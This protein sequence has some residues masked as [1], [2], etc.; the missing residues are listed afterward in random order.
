MGAVVALGAF[1]TGP[2][3]M[4]SALVYVASNPCFVLLNRCVR[5]GRTHLRRKRQA[6][7]GRPIEQIAAAARRLG[8]QLLHA[9]DG[10]SR[11]RIDAIRR[12]YDDVLAEGCRA[13]GFTHLLGVLAEGPE[14]DYERRRVEVMLMGAGMALVDVY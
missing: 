11:T 8:G 5:W 3:L 12:S 14:L 6:P 13:L 2:L 7:V 4:L 1:W 10:R 9:D